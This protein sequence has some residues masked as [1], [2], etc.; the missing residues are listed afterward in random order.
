MVSTELKHVAQVTINRP[1]RM[2]A[3]NRDFFEDVRAFFTAASKDPSIRVVVLSAEGKHFSAGLDLEDFRDLLMPK[4]TQA[5]DVARDACGMLNFV[6]G[7]QDSFA[8]V[9]AC[10]KP[11]IAAV[12]GACV[13]GGVDL[14]LAAD[15]R[16]CTRDAHFCVKEVDIGICADMGTLQLLPKAVGSDSLARELVYTARKLPASEALSCG[17]VSKVL[18]DAAQMREAALE[19]ATTI[20]GKSPVAVQ[21]TKLHL[22]YARDHSVADSLKHQALWNAIMLRSKDVPISVQAR[23]RNEAP[24]FPDL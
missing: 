18:D 24:S 13:G 2:N 17:L 23:M 1:D 7:L 21:G 12:Q 5:F 6:S 3:M 15:M 10:S 20:A 14:V 9:T 4:N 16:L 11:V 8:A 22:N 19:L